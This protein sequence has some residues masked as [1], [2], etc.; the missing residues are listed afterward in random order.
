MPGPLSNPKH[1]HFAQ[2]IAEE[3][4]CDLDAYVEAGFTPSLREES[5]MIT[6]SELSIVGIFSGAGI[7]AFWNDHLELVVQAMLILLA[8]IAAIF[9]VWN[10]YLDNRM[11]RIE[12]K[13][14]EEGYREAH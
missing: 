11:K 13:K 9:M 6:R 14:M 12:L 2:L 7:V 3:K 8:L 4:L 10:R 5:K 1:E